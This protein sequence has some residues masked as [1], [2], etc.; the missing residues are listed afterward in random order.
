MEA[1]GMIETYGLVPS[2]EAADAMLKAAEV[3][4]LERTFVKGGLVTITVTGDVAAVK[5]SVDAGAA[6]A[7]RLGENA[8][9]TQHVIPRPHVEIGEQ[10]VNPIPLAELK[11]QEEESA[12]EEEGPS[13]GLIE[14]AQTEEEPAQT[15]E[16]AVEEPAVEAVAPVKVDADDLCK[17]VIDALVAEQ[18][19]DAAMDIVGKTK[20]VKLRTIAREYDGL[21]IAGREISKANKSVIMD[22]I[23][24]FYS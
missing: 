12:D 7:A 5:A 21:G 13:T 22:E 18:G 19:L 23:K 6:A 4:L 2:I 15:V 11:A 24:K 17:E 14:E 10:I 9:R 16:N 20:V 1:L 3:R 8:L